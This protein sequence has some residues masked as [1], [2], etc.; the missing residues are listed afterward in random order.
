VSAGG[1]GPLLERISKV[2]GYIAASSKGAKKGERDSAY[3]RSI[4]T[5]GNPAGSDAQVRRHVTYMRSV[6]MIMGLVTKQ[7]P[8]IHMCIAEAMHMCNAE[9]RT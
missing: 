2:L 9:A 8:Q 1:D 6:G 5:G 7:E 4:L 3:I